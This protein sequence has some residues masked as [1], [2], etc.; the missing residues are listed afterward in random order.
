MNSPLSP[1]VVRP[2]SP[3]I[4]RMKRM[5]LQPFDFSKWLAIGFCSWLA[6]LGG[7]SGGNFNF[8]RTHQQFP[9]DIGHELIRLKLYLLDHLAWV[10]PASVVALLLI[11][12]LVVLLLWLGSRGAFM[13]LHCVVRDR[14]EVAAPWSEYRREG[15]SLLLF[16]LILAGCG[17]ILILF[18]LALFFFLGLG[19]FGWVIAAGHVP[20]FSPL[21][22]GLVIG[23][24]IFFLVW[25]PLLITVLF[26]NE[27]VVPIMFLRRCT[28]TEA[29][30]EFLN[31]LGEHPGSF[32]R[33]LLFQIVISIVVVM[34][35]LAAI[36][37][38][39]CICLILLILPVV[40]SVVVLPISV[41]W[42]NYSLLYLA[43]FGPEYDLL[44]QEP[45]AL[46]QV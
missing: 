9:R 17:L 31:L 33:Y 39:C 10:I 16:R 24:G 32:V 29:W 26:T 8:N 30:G 34:I 20:K 21:V 15:N 13:F 22:T 19:G 41:F 37:C 12:G 1:S 43:Q 38:T 4:E 45:P 46:P 6:G 14:G 36:L 18:A 11:L 35:A 42:R 7:S 5:L 23:V 2:V 44:R 40:G 3:A 28:C 27:F 25:L